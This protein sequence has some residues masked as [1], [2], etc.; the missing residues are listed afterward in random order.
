MKYLMVLV[1]CLIESIWQKMVG[2]LIQYLLH[3]SLD[4]QLDTLFESFRNQ[5]TGNCCLS[6]VADFISLLHLFLI[7]LFFRPFSLIIAFITTVFA[8]PL[9]LWLVNK[10]N[11]RSNTA[12][13]T[14][15]RIKCHTLVLHF[16]CRRFL[17]LR[18]SDI[19]K[20]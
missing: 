18:L 12:A 15:S 4:H 17:F 2:C 19:I 16:H 5:S 13:N 9:L 6:E 3:I 7:W 8:K 11:K 10:S 1:G 20:G 14:C